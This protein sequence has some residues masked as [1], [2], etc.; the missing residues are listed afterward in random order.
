MELVKGKMLS[1]LI[2][3][4]SLTTERSIEIIGDVA[5]ALDEAHRHGIV[6]RDIKPSDVAINE[7]AKSRCWTLT[8]QN[9]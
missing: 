7:Q 2:D 6:H 5:A 3:E 8:W 4:K 9:I 1:D